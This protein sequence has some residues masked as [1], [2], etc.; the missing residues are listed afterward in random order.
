MASEVSICNRA[1]QI[2]GADPITALSESNDR[3]RALTIAYSAIRD[4]ELERRVWRFAIKRDSLAA[5]SDA[6]IDDFAY[7]Y[8]VPNDFLRLIRGGDLVP[9]PNTADYRGTSD[10]LWSREGD[11]I[12]TNLSAP[13]SIRYIARIT[14][15]SLFS[16]AFCEALSARIALETCERITQSSTK[17]ADAKDAYKMAIREAA[18]A[19]AFEL[20][21]E[22]IGE[23]SWVTARLE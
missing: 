14:D 21:P 23:G 15:V 3:S 2:L 19:N 12:L 4:A 6:P 16:P 22:T 13:L 20:A 17:K 11:R 7:Q 5:L 1:L 9:Y 10:A 8:Q 18:R